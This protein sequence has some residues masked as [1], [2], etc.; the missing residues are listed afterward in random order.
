M[1]GSV[2]I[3]HIEINEYA[4]SLPGVICA[5]DHPN[6]SVVVKG[7]PKGFPWAWNER[8]T[9]KKPKVR[10]DRVV[11]IRT[12]NVMVKRALVESGEPWFF[13][14]PHYE[15][16]PAVLVKLDLVPMDVLESL[17]EA[18]YHLFQK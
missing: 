11:A 1:L 12:P 18:A 5:P 16:Y 15:N 17:I 3:S 7:K 14:E 9:P 10:N 8:V 6:L 4:N 13:D 2:A